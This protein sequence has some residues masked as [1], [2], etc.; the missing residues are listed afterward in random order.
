[1]APSS[2]EHILLNWETLQLVERFA[3]VLYPFEAAD[4]FRRLPKL[5]YIVAERILFGARVEV[6]KPIATKGDVELVMNQDNKTL[7]IMGRDIESVLTEFKNLR[8]FWT[9][10][11]DPSPNTSTHYVEI[12]C[13]AWAKAQRSPLQA[14]DP[15]AWYSVEFCCYDLRL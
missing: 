10:Y 8:E 12:N 4:L 2:R 13:S 11:L 7:G 15:T 5:G 9:K 6:G 1:M 3:N 14:F